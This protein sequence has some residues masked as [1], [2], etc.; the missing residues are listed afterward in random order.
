MG[1]IYLPTWNMMTTLS[2]SVKIFMED[3]LRLVQEHEKE[4]ANYRMNPFPSTNPALFKARAKFIEQCLLLGISAEHL[5]KAILLKNGFI[6]NKVRGLPQ[7]KFDQVLLDR[8]EKLGNRQDRNELDSIYQSAR[9]MLGQVSG[10]T[11]S[12]EECVTIFYRE[13]VCD[14]QS[15]F[16]DLSQKEYNVANE[17]TKEFYGSVINASNALEKIKILRNNYAHLPDPMYE[18]RGLIPFLYSFL[19]FVAK[20]EFPQVMASLRSI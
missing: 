16:S 17:E 11:I 4:I 12:F 13:I 15:F 9:A 20:K 6:I 14:I 7:K 19:V 5:L 18:E 2:V 8:I 3:I 1:R 10:R